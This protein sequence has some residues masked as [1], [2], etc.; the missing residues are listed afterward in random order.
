[1]G[2]EPPGVQKEKKRRAAAV[3]R[4]DVCSSP[5]IPASRSLM[6]KKN[7]LLP[8]QHFGVNGWFSFV[9]LNVPVVWLSRTPTRW[10]PEKSAR[11]RLL[12]ERR[13]PRGPIISSKLTRSPWCHG[14]LNGFFPAGM[15]GDGQCGRRVGG[16]KLR[17]VFAFLIML[18]PLNLCVSVLQST[19]WI[20]MEIIIKNNNWVFAIDFSHHFNWTYIYIWFLFL[21]HKYYNTNLVC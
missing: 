8:P 11:S 18:L 9:F 10:A 19:F 21:S 6:W 14:S 1:M 15:E 13:R 12:A 5:L 3:R 2:F 20:V 16:G 4:A 7:T 17:S